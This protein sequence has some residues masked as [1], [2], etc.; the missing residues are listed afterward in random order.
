MNNIYRNENSEEFEDSTEHYINPSLNYWFNIRHGIF[1]EYGLD[2]GYFQR[3]PDMIGNMGK[4]RYTYRF[5]PRTSIFGEYTY[6]R[7]DFDSQ[8]GT[9]AASVDYEVHTPAVGFE[10][11]FSRTLSVRA[12][13]G[14]F[15]GIPKT[16]SNEQAPYYDVVLTQRAQRTTYTLGFQ[17]GYIEDY[18]SADNQG[19]AKYNQVV[20]TISHQLTQRASATLSGRYQRPE[21]IDGRIDNLY[22]ADGGVSYQLFRWL[23][24]GLNFSYAQNASAGEEDDYKDYRG[25]FRI[26]AA[27]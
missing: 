12:S 25:M 13:G 23:T 8:T 17:G 14:Y 20:G 11:A 27:Y 4:G 26:T 7:R 10:H 16:G 21:Y 9:A 19:F 2:L 22:G 24:L 1:L 3:S 6:Q 15:W 18:F 5:N